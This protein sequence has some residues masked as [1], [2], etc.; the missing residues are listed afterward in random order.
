VTH[1][2]ESRLPRWPDRLGPEALR[3][4][5]GDLYAW[6]D[7]SPT[8]GARI[9]L[10]GDFHSVFISTGML[11]WL[12]RLD[13]L[14]EQLQ[15][16]AERRWPDRRPPQCRAGIGLQLVERMREREWSWEEAALDLLRSKQ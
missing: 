4:A 9:A 5:H 14:L 12:P 11:W 8:A 2:R 16:A 15:L 6:R 13:Q 10:L 7:T 1:C 3:L